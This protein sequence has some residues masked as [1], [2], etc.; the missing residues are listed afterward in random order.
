[1]KLYSEIPAP[2]GLFEHAQVKEAL[3][4][5]YWSEFERAIAAITEFLND[6]PPEDHAIFALRE[7]VPWWAELGNLD[8]AAKVATQCAQ[9]AIQL[10][11]SLDPMA[12]V[13]RNTQMYWLGKAG[14]QSKA[15]ECARSLLAD[16][17]VVL[18]LKE[19]LHAAVRNNAA[20]VFEGGEYRA[21]AESIYIDLISD[22]EAWGQSE[23]EHCFTTRDNYVQFLASDGRVSEARDLMLEQILIF[24][25][26]YGQYSPITLRGRYDASI[27]SLHLGQMDSA[28][29]QL[30]GLAQDCAK[31]LD[32]ADALTSMVL[33]VL[34]SIVLEQDDAAAVVQVTTRLLDQAQY[35]G[36]PCQMSAGLQ[37]LR[38]RYRD[39]CG[40]SH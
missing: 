28:R 32:V 9:R 12:L 39:L 27:L 16:A 25:K 37:Q 18:D 22:F 24:T 29:E 26:I 7:T 21:E 33:S 36:D 31:H 2:E 4:A 15:E 10:W 11:G 38:N 23:T 13:M 6:D 40:V 19:P 35:T 17:A 8:R 30:E 1:M 14:K 20:R 34:L 5:A 3:V